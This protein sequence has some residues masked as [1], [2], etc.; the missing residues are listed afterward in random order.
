[1]AALIDKVARAYDK[2][3]VKFFP[4][5]L[6]LTL[7]QPDADTDAYTPLLDLSSGWFFEYDR[8]RQTFRFEIARDDDT[9]TEAMQAATHLAVTRGGEGTDI[10]AIADGDTVPPL[11]TD[12]TWKLYCTRFESADRFSIVR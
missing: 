7:I 9:L 1:M 3:R 4:D 2:V 10:Y 5:T 11:G 8:F 12:V 6:L